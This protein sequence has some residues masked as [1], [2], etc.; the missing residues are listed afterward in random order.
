MKKKQRI[1]VT[2]TRYKLSFIFITSQDTKTLT[3]A[4]SVEVYLKL[5]EWIQK[6]NDNCF[7]VIV[8]EYSSCYTFIPGRLNVPVW[9]EN[10]RYCH[11]LEFSDKRLNAIHIKYMFSEKCISAWKISSYFSEENKFIDC[12]LL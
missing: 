5:R 11:T 12:L 7:K 9:S 2:N 3:I 4:L 1:S 6:L 10:T 8:Q